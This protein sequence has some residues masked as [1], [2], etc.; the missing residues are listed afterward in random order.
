[1]EY[2]VLFRIRDRLFEKRYQFTE[3]YKIGFNIRR[4]AVDFIN[5][6]AEKLNS[7]KIA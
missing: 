5:E 7:Y 6:F 1:M 3:Y 2:L 4:K